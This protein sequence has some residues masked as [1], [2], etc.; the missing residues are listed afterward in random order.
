MGGWEEADLRLWRRAECLDLLGEPWSAVLDGYLEAWRAVRARLSRCTQSRGTTGARTASSS[1]TCSPSAPAR[2]HSLRATTSSSPATST[3][4][5]LGRDGD[6]R[7]LRRSTEESFDLCNELLEGDALPEAD[8]DRSKR[9]GTSACLTWPPLERYPEEVI[10][11]IL[12][13]RT[14]EVQAAA[15]VTLSITS[16]RR[17]ALFERTV[18]SFLNCC[19]VIDRIAVD[20][21][22]HGFHQSDRDRMQEL[23]PFFEFVFTDRGR[24]TGTPP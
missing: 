2:S 18:N 10:R 3:T 8:D 23:Y 24:A 21:R 14:K 1:A 22:G 15:D 19:T 12:A 17:L 4:G 6:L 7:L 11:S 5:A 16:C 13:R 9:I 20:L